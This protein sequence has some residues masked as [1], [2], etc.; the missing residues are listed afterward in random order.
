[1]ASYVLLPTLD[2][3]EEEPW[4]TRSGRRAGYFFSG[5]SA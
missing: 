4:G 1:M 5:S 3:A 2:F